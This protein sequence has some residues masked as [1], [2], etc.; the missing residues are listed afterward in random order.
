MIQHF[1]CLMIFF[2]A[3]LGLVL[4]Q[5]QTSQPMQTFAT[6]EGTVINRAGG[7]IVGAKVTLTH[8]ERGTS[9]VVQTNAN[10]SFKIVDL[11]PGIYK[12]QIEAKE[13]ESTVWEMNLG[14]GDM[15]GF[16]AQLKGGGFDYKKDE[17]EEQDFIK[18]K[19][20]SVNSLKKDIKKNLPLGSSIAQVNEFLKQRSIEHSKLFIGDSD[21]DYPNEKNLR[22]I[23]TSIRNVRKGLLGNWG[24]FISF[25]FDENDHLIDYKVKWVG[26]T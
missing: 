2:A 13:F 7:V 25:R 1:I 8:I 9:C 14:L 6:L 26:L 24:I 12:I 10:G 18:N 20:L 11:P 5:S 4:P 15:K 23:H 22:L 19:I 3:N 21:S 16:T 17:N